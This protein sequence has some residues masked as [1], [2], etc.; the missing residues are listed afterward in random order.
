MYVGFKKITLYIFIIQKTTI[1]ERYNTWM[2]VGLDDF[3][4]NFD[5]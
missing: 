4:N 1:Y 3:Q 5:S 2:K